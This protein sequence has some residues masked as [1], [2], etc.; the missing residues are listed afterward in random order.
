MVPAP[1]PAVEPAEVLPGVEGRQRH[2][3]SCVTRQVRSV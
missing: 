1:V 3:G 2:C